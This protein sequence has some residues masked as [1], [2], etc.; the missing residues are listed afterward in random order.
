[1]SNV[2]ISPQTKEALLLN[3]ED[4]I[5]FLSQE[6]W[7]DYP[8]AQDILKQFNALKKREQNKMRVTSILL[9]G[10]SNNG[11]TALLSRFV[12][13]NPLYNMFETAPEKCTDDFLSKYNAFGIPVVYTMA[14]TEPSES[15]LYSNILS[16]M[17]APY[18]E[19]NSI[20]QKFELVKHYIS[21][22]NVEML[23]IDEIHNILSGSVARQKQ[24]MNSIKNLS[25]I[26]KIPIV[27]AGI[28][29]SLRAINTDVQIASR[30]RPVYLTKWEMNKEYIS[31]LATI[32]SYLPLKKESK[33]LTPDVALE[34]LKISEGYIGDI[35]EL[36]QAA[37]EYA[38]ISKT[39]R[40][41][42]KEIKDC[43]YNS[44]SLTQKNSL[45]QKV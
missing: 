3:D 5:T 32:T 19:T 44:M 38:I 4:R 15:R 20:A 41:T 9:V 31:L 7:I 22:F 39:E 23:I 12:E 40:I 30:F 8:A 16:A 34:I 10:S 11:K 36:I 25:N 45:L 2:E 27:L 6:R 42:I 37:A 1:M 14:P 18:K 24:V 21:L 13:L 33:I 28:K 17:N 35:I 43:G 29:D 26:L